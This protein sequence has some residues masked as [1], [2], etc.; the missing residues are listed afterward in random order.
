MI[1]I[2]IIIIN[3]S[4]VMCIILC[5][6]WWPWRNLVQGASLH[7]SLSIRVQLSI[8]MGS[9]R[10]FM[11]GAVYSNLCIEISHEGVNILLSAIV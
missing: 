11:C 6:I 1:I 4:A 7:K 3:T 10:V 9:Y 2:I 8:S 5:G